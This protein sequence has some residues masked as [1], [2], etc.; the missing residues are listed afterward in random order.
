MTL[1]GNA[2]GVGLSRGA[3]FV[4][5]WLDMRDPE[6]KKHF[7]HGEV[8]RITSPKDLKK[9]EKRIQEMEAALREERLKLEGKNAD[10]RSVRKS[11]V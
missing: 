5:D 2:K 4:S 7:G 10:L 9:E 1:R 11:K 8:K 6:N 3:S